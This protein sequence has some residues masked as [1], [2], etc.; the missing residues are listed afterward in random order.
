MGRRV[1][2]RSTSLFVP[3]HKRLATAEQKKKK[4]MMEKTKEAVC[5]RLLREKYGLKSLLWSIENLVNAVRGQPVAVNLGHTNM[6]GKEVLFVKNNTFVYVVTKFLPHMP[7][8]ATT[9][10]QGNTYL[11]AVNDGWEELPRSQRR[12]IVAHELAHIQLGHVDSVWRALSARAKRVLLKEFPDE[13]E[14]DRLAVSAGH[15]P[16]LVMSLFRLRREMK[17]IGSDLREVDSR[18]RHIKKLL[19]EKSQSAI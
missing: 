5:K 10:L 12:S 18:V 7:S 2:T 6:D 17:P 3:K 8:A 1:N 15:G 16:G 4:A 13:L 9:R 14:A 19:K 11:V